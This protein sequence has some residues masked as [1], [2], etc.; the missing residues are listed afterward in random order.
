MFL[1]GGRP[2][3]DHP[4]DQSHSGLSLGSLL[5]P[6]YLIVSLIIWLCVV[7]LDLVT[8]HY[9]SMCDCVCVCLVSTLR[10]THTLDWYWR[11]IEEFFF[12]TLLVKGRRGQERGKINKTSLRFILFLFQNKQ[13]HGG[14]NWK[15]RSRLQRIMQLLWSRRF[16]IEKA[17]HARHHSNQRGDTQ[18]RVNRWFIESAARF[19]ILPTSF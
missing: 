7:A 16:R 10:W 15:G 12:T 5:M 8:L 13:S 9:V 19:H 2:P 1:F 11:I 18:V 3:V 14:E 17:P 4:R 6:F